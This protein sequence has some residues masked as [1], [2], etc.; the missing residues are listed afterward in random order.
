MGSDKD[1]KKLDSA[2]GIQLRGMS[3]V[4]RRVGKELKDARPY[5]DKKDKDDDGDGK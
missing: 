2:A 5:P 3:R 4:M 1:K